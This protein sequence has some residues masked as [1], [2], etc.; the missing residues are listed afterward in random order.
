MKPIPVNPDRLLAELA[1]LRR[2]GAQGKGVARMAFSEP[3]LAS[4][5]LLAERMRDAGLEVTVD[6]C[7]NLFGIPP[8]VGPCLLIGSHSDTQPLGGWLDG[9]YGVLCGLEVARASLESGGPRVA[10][11]SFQDEEGRFGGLTGSAV[12]AGVM[13]LAEADAL[14]DAEGA[15]F[16]DARCTVGRIAPVAEVP[17][18]RFSAYLEAHIEQGP[19]LDQSNEAIGVVEAIVGMRGFTLRFVGQANHAGT[20]P[21]HLR[22]DALR[23]AAQFIRDLEEAFA[24]HVTEKTVWTHGHLA[25]EPNAASIVPGKASL[26]VQMRDP[27]SDRLETLM[28]IALELAETI[29][30]DRELALEIE[31][32]PRFEPVPMSQALVAAITAAAETHAAGAWRRMPSGALHD[33]S[34][35]AQVLPVGMMFVPSIGGISHNP[36]EDTAPE[37]LVRGLVTLADAAGRLA[38]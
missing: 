4:R 19:V 20:T 34:N 9:I 5:A 21:M 25:V 11:V 16:A 6:A 35:V 18:G 30:R 2:F 23:A 27:D 22:R 3:D 14:H 28:A 29:A 32:G 12:W 17:A 38:S 26:S 13:P 36:D 24:P 1:E 10:V 15:R 8:G 31:Q 7:G 37:H 33:A